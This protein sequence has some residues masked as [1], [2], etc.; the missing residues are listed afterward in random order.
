MKRASSSSQA[1]SQASERFNRRLNMYSL[2]AGATGVG[3][4]AL[5]PP[6]H[7]E[8]VYTAANVAISALGIRSYPLDLNH[9][10]TTD[11]FINAT[12]KESVDTSG[13]TSRIMVKA[14]QGNGAVGYGGSAADLMGGAPIGT[15]RKFDGKLLGVLRTFIGTEFSFHGNWANVTN[16]YLG[17]EFQIDG[18]THF[19]WA[20]ISMP[21]K[22]PLTATL[23]GYAYETI[24]NTP[25]IAGK[26]SGTDK[27][28]AALPPAGAPSLKTNVPPFMLGMLALGAPSLSIWRR[29]EPA[30]GLSAD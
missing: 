1:D 3:L 10:G 25:I 9:D 5:A 6:A 17:F 2:A 29:R 26:T 8:I 27:A 21:G 28:K 11:F 7:G 15:A 18:Q 23:T 16:R 30:T 22:I 24:A 20:R 12:F 19:G 4:L 14:A 13:G